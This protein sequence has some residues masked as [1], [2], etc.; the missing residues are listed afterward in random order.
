MKLHYDPTTDSLY[1]ELADSPSVESKEIAQGVVVDYDAKGD[2]V[3]ID[4][5]RASGKTNLNVLET[6]G[7]PTRKSRVA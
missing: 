7:L 2:V 3:G 1:V 5:E 4:I 6:A